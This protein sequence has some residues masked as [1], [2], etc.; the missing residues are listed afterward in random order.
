MP[1]TVIPLTVS[2]IIKLLLSPVY[3]VILPDDEIVNSLSP[4]V[5]TT[6]YVALMYLLCLSSLIAVA[7]IC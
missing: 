7:I 1:L 4:G 2:G 3:P 6:W 5:Y